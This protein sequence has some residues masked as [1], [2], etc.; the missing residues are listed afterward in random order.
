[1]AD[2][3]LYAA[4]GSNMN[5]VQMKHRCPLARKIG[6]GIIENYELVFARNGYADIAAKKNEI[7]PVVVWELTEACERSLDV[8]EG[9][10]N[11]LAVQCYKN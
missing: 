3:K 4:Y 6:T 9:Y 1:M 11:E 5:T 8:Y 2:K 7:V 10:P